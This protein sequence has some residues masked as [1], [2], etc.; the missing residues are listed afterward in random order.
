MLESY[1]AKLTDSPPQ[2]FRLYPVLHYHESR[3][4]IKDLDVKLS[5]SLKS[6]VVLAIEIEVVKQ[7]C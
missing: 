5:G 6:N 7:G 2:A 4:Q 1:T 3:T